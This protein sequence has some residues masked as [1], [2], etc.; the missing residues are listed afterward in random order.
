MDASMIRAK[1]MRFVAQRENN[2]LQEFADKNNITV[3]EPPAS[4]DWSDS[5]TN[6]EM[7]LMMAIVDRLV[8]LSTPNTTGTAKLFLFLFFAR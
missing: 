3:I 2:A 8:V 1:W 4:D 7:Y 6:R 5:S